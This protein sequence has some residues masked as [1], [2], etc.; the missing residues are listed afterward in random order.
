MR[1]W[2]RED[3]PLLKWFEPFYGKSVFG[4]NVEDEVSDHLRRALS[5]CLEAEDAYEELVD[6]ARA[7]RALNEDGKQRKAQLFQECVEAL[8]SIV[9][10]ERDVDRNDIDL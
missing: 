5:C 7:L 1:R 3:T 8:I 2:F 4:L 10:M 6:D 9:D